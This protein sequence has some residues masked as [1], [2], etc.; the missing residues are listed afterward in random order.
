[1][2][3]KNIHFGEGGG[4]VIIE[5]FHDECKHWVEIERFQISVIRGVK[6]SVCSF[7]TQLGIWSGPVAVLLRALSKFQTYRSEITGM[8][9]SLLIVLGVGSMN[10]SFEQS[11]AK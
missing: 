7:Q 1:M 11:L 4:G 2:C 9:T 10:I 5:R 8:S 6:I 3:F